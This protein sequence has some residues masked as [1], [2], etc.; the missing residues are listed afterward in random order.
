MN[1]H[2]EV[3]KFEGQKVM[4][5]FSEKSYSAAAGDLTI[6]KYKAITRAVSSET[7]QSAKFTSL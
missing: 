5:I 6:S 1:L 7:S 4:S 3:L 2:F